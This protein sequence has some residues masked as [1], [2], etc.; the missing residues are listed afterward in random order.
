MSTDL[1]HE[2]AQ[3][4]DAA[5]A[6]PGD[7]VEEVDAKLQRILPEYSPQ[8]TSELLD[9]ISERVIIS[10]DEWIRLVDLVDP[11]EESIDVRTACIEGIICPA[12]E[13]SSLLV[14]FGNRGVDD[15]SH[16]VADA[17]YY[18]VLWL[19]YRG[20]ITRNAIFRA[21]APLSDAAHLADIL[22]SLV[23]DQRI[24][25]GL[26]VAGDETTYVCNRRNYEFALRR[27]RARRN[28]EIKTRPWQHLAIDIARQQGL[29]DDLRGFEGLMHSLE[30][31]GALPM[32]AELWES[33]ILP[34]RIKGYQPLWLDRAAYEESVT[35]IGAPN[36]HVALLLH[37][38]LE[39]YQ[40]D[41]P[42]PS[43]IIPSDEGHYTFDALRKATGKSSVDLCE[44]LWA[45]AWFGQCSNDAFTALR[46]GISEGY[47]AP[48]VDRRQRGRGRAAG[49]DMLTGRWYVTPTV[50]KGS[51]L[52]TDELCKDRVRLLLGRY[53]VLFRTLLE[54]EAPALRWSQLFRALRLLE[55]AGEVISGRIYDGI[56][57]VQFTTSDNL[58]RMQAGGDEI[59]FWINACDPATLCGLKLDATLPPRRRTTHLA[60]IGNTLAAISYRNGRQMS[61]LVPPNH[62]QLIDALGF[63]SHLLQRP[64]KPLTRVHIEPIN[65]ESAVESP[66][67]EIL[68]REFNGQDEG[69]EL[70]VYR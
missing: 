59:A 6:I 70:L 58:E 51:P 41:S 39:L 47:R 55:L 25:E 45:E 24:V 21:F 28:T 57:G 37:G 65:D 19:R 4:P 52:E 3:Q 62:P 36:T 12:D 63:I 2:I 61:M 8:N 34:A 54:R 16:K 66:Y 33:D 5:I 56:D 26:L 11:D 40:Q 23:Q 22:D 38:D 9:W 29:L 18:V 20:P 13:E 60:Y 68:L 46:S 7:I 15:G 31:L 64:I 10:A 35:W 43:T 42:P 14:A 44:A 50:A 17:A 69:G 27:L 1:V 53:P 67:A 49:A 48:T 32:P 30:G